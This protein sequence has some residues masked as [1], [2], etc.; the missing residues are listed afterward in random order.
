MS[1]AYVLTFPTVTAR[2]FANL[3]N[4]LAKSAKITTTAAGTGNLAIIGDGIAAEAAY[5]PT[6][7]TL[8][9]TIL[10]RP[11]YL[12]VSAI[13]DHIQKALFAATS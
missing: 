4:E 10:D 9:V 1:Q 12:T 7:Q 13:Q 3:R 6:N 11:W 2:T 8:I 5:N